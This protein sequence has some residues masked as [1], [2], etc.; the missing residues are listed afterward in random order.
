LALFYPRRSELSTG[1]TLI[2]FRKNAHLRLQN[3][4]F[5]ALKKMRR[6]LYMRIGNTCVFT[7]SS[8]NAQAYARFD[9]GD[10]KN[11]AA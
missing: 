6:P 9:N 4:G 2:F 10:G 11:I 5:S 7:T 1:R 3:P 8:R